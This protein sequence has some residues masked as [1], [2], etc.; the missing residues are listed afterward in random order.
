MKKIKSAQQTQQK[1]ELKPKKRFSYYK[2]ILYSSLLVILIL[3][4]VVVLSQTLSPDAGIQRPL[5]GTQSSPRDYPFVNPAEECYVHNKTTAVTYMVPYR[6][7]ME[8]A[9]FKSFASKNASS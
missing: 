6:S 5:S 4:V 1:A 2:L 9:A 3:P 8:W 7:A